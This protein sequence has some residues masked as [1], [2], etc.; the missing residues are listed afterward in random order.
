VRPNDIEEPYR[1]SAQER[2]L[3]GA[4]SRRVRHITL[5]VMFRLPSHFSVTPSFPT[6]CL[7]HIMPNEGTQTNVSEG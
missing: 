1:V 2:C 4:R 5:P 7:R 3:E 6:A